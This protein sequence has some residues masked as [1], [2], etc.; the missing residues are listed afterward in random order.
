V[1]VAVK[2]RNLLLNKE[3]WR[4]GWLNYKRAKM[5][6]NVKEKCHNGA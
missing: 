4:Y 1:P 3:L 6:H 5:A 2:C